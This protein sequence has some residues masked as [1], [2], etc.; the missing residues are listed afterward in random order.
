MGFE[1]LVLGIIHAYGYIIWTISLW[2]LKPN[3]KAVIGLQGSIWTISLWDL[4]HPCTRIRINRNRLIWTIS[5]WDL[6]QFE[7][8][9]ISITSLFEL[10]PYG[11]WNFQYVSIRWYT[12]C[13]WTIS[14]WD[15]KPT[16]PP[17]ETFQVP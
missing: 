11:I 12:N 13:I 4:K 17:S 16:L 7:A 10:F 5:L 9:V 6:K 1:T 8:C 14:L 2:D 3:M 15:L